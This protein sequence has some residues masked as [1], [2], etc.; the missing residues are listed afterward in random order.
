M[1]SKLNIFIENLF[2]E[3]LRDLILH[4]MALK[5]NIL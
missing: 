2:D 4:R 3:R 1:K 5:K